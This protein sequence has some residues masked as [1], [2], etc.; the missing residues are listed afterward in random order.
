LREEYIADGDGER[1]TELVGEEE[2][3]AEE[4]DSADLEEEEESLE[5]EWVLS[6]AGGLEFD[7]AAILLYGDSS[8]WVKRSE[9][10][11]GKEGGRLLVNVD[12]EGRSSSPICCPDNPEMRQRLGRLD[13]S[14]DCAKGGVRRTLKQG[15][16]E[17][18]N[19]LNFFPPTTPNQYGFPLPHGGETRIPYP[20]LVGDSD[21]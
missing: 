18:E 7:L 9:R 2:E 19:N 3:E 20:N 6:R 8:L 14:P 13:E 16:R 12:G 5:D 17:D 21:D 15:Q 4:L 10:G 11:E 1:N